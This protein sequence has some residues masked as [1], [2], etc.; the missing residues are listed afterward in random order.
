V[1]GR[2]KAVLLRQ[3]RNLSCYDALQNLP[4][5][6]KERN[7]STRLRGLSSQSPLPVVLRKT[8]LQWQN[9]VT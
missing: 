7:R 2:E 5:F 1:L 3:G 4:K 6:I 8:V 9:A